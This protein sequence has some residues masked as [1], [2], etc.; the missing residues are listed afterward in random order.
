MIVEEENCFC[1]NFDS[2]EDE[3]VSDLSRLQ[4]FKTFDDMNLD[5]TKTELANAEEL[6]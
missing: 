1:D 3:M 5:D 2:T 6:T 4:T